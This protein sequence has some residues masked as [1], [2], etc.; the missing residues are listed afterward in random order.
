MSFLSAIGGDAGIVSTAGLDG[1]VILNGYGVEIYDTDF[2]FSSTPTTSFVVPKNVRKIRAIVIGA[3]GGSSGSQNVDGAQA[4]AGAEGF[5]T[6]TP[7]E[8]LTVGV[9]RGGQGRDTGNPGDGGDS[10]IRRGSTTLIQAN[11]GVS[12]LSRTGSSNYS[13]S[14]FTFDSSV[15]QISGGRG[16]SGGSQNYSPQTDL[17]AQSEFVNL[18]GATAHAGGA[19]GWGNDIPV[20][21]GF[22]IG[23]GGGGGWATSVGPRRDGG[24]FGF[25]GGS[26]DSGGCIRGGGP[27]GGE[28]NENFSTNGN[29]GGG[30]GSFGGSGV[31]GWSGGFG[32]GGLVR[33]WWASSDGDVEFIDSG[34]N[35]E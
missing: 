8:T 33:I 2:G 34:G 12:T 25:R 27:V 10:F 22:G 16:G 13:R 23:F 15:T 35:Y 9:G 26:G 20:Q 17:D 32:A 4:G 24:I 3:G 28:G 30:G 19:G 1:E 29:S 21:R 18:S 5:I 31:D 6:V 11:G 7:G 14:T